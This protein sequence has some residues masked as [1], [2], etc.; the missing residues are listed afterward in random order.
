MHF[1]YD[2]YVGLE[3]LLGACAHLEHLQEKRQEI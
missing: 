1:T 3:T 2:K